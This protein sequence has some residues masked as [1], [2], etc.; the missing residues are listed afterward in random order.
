MKFKALKTINTGLGALVAGETLEIELDKHTFD[1]WVQNGLIEEVKAN[2]K[3][4]K[5]KNDDK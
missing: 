1:N 4:V 3:K 2:R 5:A